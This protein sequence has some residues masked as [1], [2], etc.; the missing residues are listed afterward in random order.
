MPLMPGTLISGT[1]IG[2]YEILSA[3]GAGGMGQVY[4]ARDTKLD[5]EVAIKVLP[6]NVAHDRERLA[7]FAREA[8]VLASLNHPHIAQIYGLEENALVME[9][10][11]GSTLSVPQPLETALDY[12]RQIAEALEA[13]HEK[14]ITHR[15]LKPGNIMVTPEGVV[16]VL[17]FGL[18]SVPSHD[19]NNGATTTEAGM[20]MGTAAY[21]SPEQAAGKSVDKRSDIWSFGVV[22]YEMLSG[23]KLFAGET[24]S[25]TLADVLRRPIEFAEVKA[26]QPIV[27]LS[28]RCLDRDVKTRLQAIG[29]ARI[30]ITRYLTDPKSGTRIPSGQ[31][32]T[33]VNWV[34]WV[35][36]TALALITSGGLYR[37]TRPAPPKQLMRLIVDLGPE[38]VRGRRSTMV[39]SPD[40]RRIV[41]A[42]QAPGGGAQLFTRLMDQVEAV[43]IPGTLGAE[44]PLGTYLDPFFSPDGEWVGFFADGKLK[45]VTV[46]GG[47]VVTLGSTAIHFGA[48]WGDDGNIVVGTFEGLQRFPAG[49]GAAQVLPTGFALFPDVLPGGQSVLFSSSRFG[50]LQLG[51]EALQFSTGQTKALLPNGYEPLYLPTSRDTGHLVYLQDGTLFAVA[52]DPRRLEIRGTPVPLVQDVS[53]GFDLSEGAGQITFAAN[54]TLAYLPSVGSGT[55]PVLWLDAA[56]KTTPLIQQP[57]AYYDPCLSPDGKWLAYTLRG[58]SGRTDVWVYD[59]ERQTPAQ[60]TFTGPGRGELVWAADSRHLI[61][62]DAAA[63]WWIRSDGSGQPQQLVGNLGNPRPFSLA[64]TGRLAIVQQD[65]ALP[66]IYTVPIDLSDLEHPKAGKEE[67]FL[68][69]P[70]VVQVDPAFSPDGKF[71]AYA[72]TESGA[73]EVFV[74]LFPGP[75]G[76][77][78]VSQSGGMFPVWSRAAHELLFLGSDDHIM[79]VD[80]STQGDLFRAGKPRVWSP[81]PVRRMGLRQNFDLSPDGKRV[82][83]FPQPESQESLHFTFL[84]N[85][86]DEVRRKAPANGKSPYGPPRAISSGRE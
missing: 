70:T 69:D 11:A 58:Q 39:L 60:L 5:R 79:A 71:L 25:D 44:G 80:Y 12:A 84:L 31:A 29:E 52:F 30:A 74:R 45:K 28:K 55:H 85:F 77:W 40:G 47:N 62:G 53:T 7:R 48:S 61:F 14:G 63:L 82:V 21:M 13:A 15:D 54:G 46:N 78:K 41:F 1:R 65:K 51:I 16:K 67:P 68:V 27:E 59:L 4:R 83:M 18:A 72:S 56:G 64:P 38:A 2:P 49:G 75:S 20:I 9:L 32:E 8:K 24:M 50:S 33:S 3:L 43:P 17:D 19:G 42:G 36:A 6:D 73:L 76:R 26:P 10:V 86:F 57:D 34:P 22:L 35:L 23:K 66:D 81:V 37:A